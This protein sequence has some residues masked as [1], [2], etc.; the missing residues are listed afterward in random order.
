MVLI[1][2]NVS[3]GYFDVSVI[4]SVRNM[5]INCSILGNWEPSPYADFLQVWCRNR[6]LKSAKPKAETLETDLLP[7]LLVKGSLELKFH[8]EW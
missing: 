3:Q 4:N 2:L 6:V 7:A 8:L 1:M 5:C